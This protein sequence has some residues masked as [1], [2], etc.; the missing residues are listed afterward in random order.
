MT[1]QEDLRRLDEDFSSGNITADEYRIRRDQVLSSAVSPQD[2]QADTSA[3][4]AEATQIVSPVSPPPQGVPPEG[5]PDVTQ[6]VPPSALPQQPPQYWQAPPEAE[7]TQA[8]QQPQGWQQQTPSPPGGFAQPPPA[9]YGHPG[10]ESPAGGFQQPHQAWG[11]PEESWSQPE[12]PSSPWGGEF[13]PIA[14]GEPDWITQGPEVEETAEKSKAGK[15]ALVA[16]AVLLLAG[17]GVG[18]FL[19]F[20]GGGDGEQGGPGPDK[21]NPTAASEPT[22]PTKTTP[23]FENPA[24]D[25]EVAALPGKLDPTNHIRSFPNAQEAGFLTEREVGAYEKGG[26]D[27]VRYTSAVLPDGVHAYVFTAAAKSPKAAQAASKAL[28]KLQLQFGMQKLSD[29]PKG[30]TAAEVDKEGDTPATVR[31]HYVHK[32]TVV[33]VQIY[34]DDL[35][36]V[37]SGF[38]QVIAAQLEA[39]KVGG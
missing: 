16:V 9:A 22:K 31:A 36:A 12:E 10:M 20:T 38:E 19:L 29:A 27:E 33:R 13:P 7:H 24:D 26:V 15:F 34:G 25:L 1:W 17:L 39:L 32:G 6:V 30:V 5:N 2:Q 14:H 37:R 8:V 35:D 18:A 28:A 11:Q 3:P 21:P 4:N 23:P